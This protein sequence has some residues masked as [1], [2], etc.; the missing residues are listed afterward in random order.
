MIELFAEGRTEEQ[1][2][3]KIIERKI[4]SKAFHPF[5]KLQGERDMLGKLKNRVIDWDKMFDKEKLNIL[6]MRDLDTDLGK[7]IKGVCDSTLLHINMVGK[8]AR[9]IPLDSHDNV[10]VIETDKLKLALHIAT[11]KYAESFTKSTIDDYILDLAML[12]NVAKI[13]IEKNEKNKKSNPW[14]ITAEKLVHKIKEEIPQLVHDNGVDLLEAKNYLWFLSGVI[15]SD[16]SPSSLAAKILSHAE[17]TDVRRV[18][19]PL[20]SAIDYLDS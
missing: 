4:C 10:F 5:P 15:R 20:L 19:A 18:F 6:V 16:A 13:L 8:G 1:V 9:L 12:E 2:V 3:K 11:K 7:T 17:E 14:T